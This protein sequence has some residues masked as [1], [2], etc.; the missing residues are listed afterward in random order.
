[1]GPATTWDAAWYL[2]I[3]RSGYHAGP[4]LLTDRGG[5]HD[6]AFWPAWPTVLAP[7]LKVVPEAWYDVTASAVANA[8]A[9]AALVLWVRVLEPAFGRRNALWGMAFVAFAPSSFVLSMGYSEPLFVLAAATFF[10]S[11]AG[12][13]RRPLLA[14][15]A[16]ATRVT[17]FALG[18]AA[19]PDLLR[20]RGRDRQ[21]WLVLVAPLL[22]FAAWWLF[23]AY[24]TGDPGGFLQGTPSWLRVTGQLSGPSSWIPDLQ[25][26][27]RYL[28]PILV[29]AVF[30]I[31][32]LIGT[33]LLFRRRLVHFGWYALAALIPTLVG[34]S[35]QSMPRHSLLAVP[36]VA[37]FIAPLRDRWRV[38]LLGLSILAEIVVCEAMVGIRLISP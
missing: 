34:A 17:G 2:S 3:A 24:L 21:A 22:V 36:A 14:A 15:L 31:A 27:P 12:S 9:I 35:W 10:L 30:M 23:L 6:F 20:S 8:L 38:P 4:L 18:A 28:R 25:H 19:I 16:Q 33:V 26:D 1:M 37:A 5:Y 7:F 32:I 11:R 13:P 29:W